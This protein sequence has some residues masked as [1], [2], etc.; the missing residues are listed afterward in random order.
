MVEGSRVV[1]RGENKR[2]STRGTK[3]NDEG[4]VK[5]C[6]REVLGVDETSSTKT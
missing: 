6:K 1:H 3:G 2:V 5:G 4:S